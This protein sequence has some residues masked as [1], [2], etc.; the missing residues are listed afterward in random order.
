M[1][2]VGKKYK[3]ETS[4]NFDE[5]MKELGVGMV[6]RKVGN[7]IHPIIF[8]EQDGDEFTYYSQSTFKNF[9]TK[10]KLGEEKEQETADG[11]KVLT[12][13][14]FDGNTLTQVEKCKKNSVI[15]RVFSD[16][17]MV[18]TSTYGDVTSK[19]VYKAI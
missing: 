2:W 13:Y 18:A 17:E 16:T 4:E 6:L 9:E 1:A 14:T 10:F 5:Y 7:T 12:T 8:L 15:V 19:R 3:L 11:R